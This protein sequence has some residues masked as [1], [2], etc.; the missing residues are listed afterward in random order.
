MVDDVVRSVI[1]RLS[2]EM[3]LPDSRKPKK[4]GML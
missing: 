3:F 4:T 1:I 2:S